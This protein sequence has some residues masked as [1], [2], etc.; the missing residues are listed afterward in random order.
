MKEFEIIQHYFTNK[1]DNRADIIL[2]I[3]DDAAIL[4]VP[5]GQHCVYTCDTLVSGTHF[6]V[7]APPKSIGHKALAVNLSDC[8]AMGAT[9]AWVSLALTLPVANDY[10]LTQF[11]EGFFQLLN[12]SGTTLIGGDLTEG[13]LSITIGV[14]GLVPKNKA[15]TRSGAQ[16]GEGIYVT[17]TLGAAG[18]AYLT[19]QQ[20]FSLSQDV[21]ARVL[22]ALHYPMP[23]T[24]EGIA[25]RGLASSLIDV[26]DG[27]YADLGHLLEMSGC[28]AE[29]QL[30]NLPLNSVLQSTLTAQQA[31]QVALTAGDDYELCFTMADE[32]EIE[33]AKHWQAAW[34]PY[35]RIGTLTEVQD[36]N[37]LGTNLQRFSPNQRGYQHFSM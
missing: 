9:P 1:C 14:H 18:L 15:I 23:R 34:A 2:G 10:W 3:G 35:Q 37:L 4:E 11:C 25:L 21:F 29:V 6:A 20:H 33:L 32:C 13:P 8:A 30:S 22:Q 31:W 12:Q 27:L 26:S 19:Q 36:F 28:G 5:N 17:G 16:P 7:D 24:Q